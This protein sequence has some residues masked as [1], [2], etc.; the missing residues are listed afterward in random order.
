MS[1]EEKKLLEEKFR[2]QLSARVSGS[3][4]DVRESTEDLL[5]QVDELT[6]R[7][8]FVDFDGARALAAAEQVPNDQT[9]GKEFLDRHCDRMVVAMARIADWLS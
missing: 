4:R 7:L 8:A 6:A 9:I 5:R 2:Q 1:P 3:T